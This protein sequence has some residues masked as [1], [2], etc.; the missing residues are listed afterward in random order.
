MAGWGNAST[1]ALRKQAYSRGSCDAV[2]VG[3]GNTCTNRCVPNTQTSPKSGC[4]ANNGSC[5]CDTTEWATLNL[6]FPRLN[7]DMTAYHVCSIPSGQCGG[8]EGFKDYFLGN[9]SKHTSKHRNLASANESTS[10]ITE[11]LKAA[12]SR[13]TP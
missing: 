4:G 8:A 1:P 6:N 3:C 9:A 5:D 12:T 7:D 2:G 10:S 13:S 11:W